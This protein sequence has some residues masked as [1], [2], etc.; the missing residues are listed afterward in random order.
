MDIRKIISGGEVLYKQKIGLIGGFGAYATLDFY[1]RFLKKFASD[2]ERNYPH[3]YMDNNYT[4]PSRT[5]ALL[6]GDNYKEIVD[7]ICSSIQ[8]MIDVNVDYIILICG[9]AHAFLP[10]IFIKIPEARNRIINIIECV[11]KTLNRK[12]I[13]KVL[14][15]AAE[16]TLQNGVYEKKLDGIECIVPQKEDYS[17]IRTF[18]EAVKQNKVDDNIAIQWYS[19]LDKFGCDNVLLGCTELPV[20]VDSIDEK[21]KGKFNYFDPLEEVLDELKERLS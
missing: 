5:R 13:R 11:K 6:C 10:D 7:E 19:F 14:V 3:I 2:C 4:M 8:L 1:E 18:I 9:T 15:V 20:L 16:G 21:W 17:Q 12:N